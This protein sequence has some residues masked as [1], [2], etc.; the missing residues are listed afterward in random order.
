[1]TFLDSKTRILKHLIQMAGK[2]GTRKGS[3]ITLWVVLN[4]DELAQ[5]AGVQM[6]VLVQVL[7][8]LQQKGILFITVDAFT[9][10]LSKLRS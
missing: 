2:H 5:M 7:R 10:D 4:Y 1:M 3:E 9:I 6:G 8:E